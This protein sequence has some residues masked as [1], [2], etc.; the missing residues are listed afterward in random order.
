VRE[1]NSGRLFAALPHRN[2]TAVGSVMGQPVVRGHGL[3][4]ACRRAETLSRI[5]CCRNQDFGPTAL[6][7]FQE[8]RN[9]SWHR[10]RNAGFGLFLQE[11]NE[12]LA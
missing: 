6:A 1:A 8:P 5:F 9:G 10:P 3:R 7:V 2:P 4:A 11:Q 12:T